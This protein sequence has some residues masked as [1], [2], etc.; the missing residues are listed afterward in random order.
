MLGAGLG[1]QDLPPDIQKQQSAARTACTKELSQL[2]E[3]A[4]AAGAFTLARA[5]LAKCQRLDAESEIWKEQIEKLAKKEDAFKKGFLK[6]FTSKQKR[7]YANCSK[8]LG[9]YAQACYKKGHR[10]EFERV[11][12]MSISLFPGQKVKSHFGVVWHEPSVHWLKPDA[13]KKLK[14][15]G[16]I[17][18]GKWVTASEIKVL[19]GQHANWDDP[20]ILTDGVHEVR[21]RMPYRTARRVMN[22]VTAF[23]K[24][25]LNQLEGKWDLKKPRGRLPVILTPG[26][27]EMIERLR[28]HSPQQ[29]QPPGSAAF[30]LQ[31]NQSLDPCFVTFELQDGNGQSATFSIDQIFMPLQHEIAHQI[32]FEYSKHDF[33]NT[34]LI[35]HQFWCVEAMANYQAN[36]DIDKGEWRL[37]KP[38]HIQV[39]AGVLEGDFAYTKKNLTKLPSLQKFFGLSRGSFNSANNYHIASTVAWFMLEQGS[40]AYAKAF[41]TL[42]E[43]VHKVRDTKDS[44]TAS[45][46]G[47][48][49]DQMQKD[50]KKFVSKI[51]LD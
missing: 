4:S 29:A 13:I 43:Q 22:R 7:A 12:D 25:F 11:L 47:V 20:W 26:R 17:I 21:T 16:E 5:E 38:S 15:G 27:T 40:P 51:K 39:G 33:D 19:N 30:Y 50:W 14:K 48:D 23:R 37:T 36:F 1:A 31:T 41:L 49:L 35:E 10:E 8:K 18:D 3:F 42:C 32:A 24:F 45:Y 2:A 9:R 28:K 46:K 34:R 6:R 44:F